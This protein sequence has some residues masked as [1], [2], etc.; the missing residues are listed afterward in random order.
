MGRGFN[1]LQ[2]LSRSTF[3]R[4]FRRFRA[5]GGPLSLH[6][7]GRAAP[8]VVSW[9]QPPYISLP[10]RDPQSRDA[11]HVPGRVPEWP[12]GADCKSADLRLRGFESLLAQSVFRLFPPENA[13]SRMT[14]PSSW[15]GLLVFGPDDFPNPA[16]CARFC[17]ASKLP[18]G[19]SPLYPLRHPKAQQTSP[20]T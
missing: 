13:S 1:S 4:R 17:A 3:P 11:G 20:S 9:C 5:T 19:N 16:L 12:I 10:F 15:R 7:H 6:A 14:S 2:R 8:P 18:T